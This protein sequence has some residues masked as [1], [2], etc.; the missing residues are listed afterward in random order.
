MMKK[1]F[2]FLA[3]LLAAQLIWAVDQSYY[4]S[5]EGKQGSDLRA[6]L[7]LLLY[8]RHTTF[9]SYNWDFPY[10]YDSEGNMLDIYSSCGFN[11][12]NK[13]ESS[14]KCCCDA[15]NREHV[16]C[17]SN[18][19]GSDNNGKIPQYSDRHHL[20]P[21][22]GRA[23]G[24]RSDLPFG[25]CSKG[26]HG[27]CNSSSTVYPGEGT[28]T[29]EN[30]EYGR[31][32]ASTFSVALPSGGGN[33]YEVGDEYKGDIAR[34]ILYMVVRYAEKTYCRLPDGAKNA[35][36]YLKTANEYPVTAWANTTQNKVGQMFSPSLSTN[37]GLS[38]YGK[39]LLLKWHR[40]DPVSQKEIDRNAGVE[41]A[42]GNR[43]PFVDYPY[44]VEYLWGEQSTKTFSRN[45]VVGSFESGFVPGESNGS[46]ESG[47]ATTYFSVTL[48]RND[49]ATVLSGLTGT[50]NL[51]TDED[52]ACENWTFAGWSTTDVSATTTQPA[53]ITSVNSEQQVY[54]VY[55]NAS[56]ESTSTNLT[57]V[58]I[59]DVNTTVGN[60]TFSADKNDGG[61]NPTY[62]ENNK[63]LRYY[64]KNSLTISS[65]SI[66]TQI[67]FT[68]S[69]QGLKRLAPITANV[70]SIAT[71]KAGDKTVTWTG[72]AT[73]VTFTVGEKADYGSD[74][75]GKA[76]QLCVSSLAI[77]SGA[78]YT[79]NSTP[80][81]PKK[82]I[83]VTFMNNGKEFATSKGEEGND[84]E[85]SEPVPCSGYEFEG[86]SSTECATE[87]DEMPSLDFNGHIP[88]EDVTYYAVYSRTQEEEEKL[89]T[90]EYKKITT[91]AELT[92]ANYLVVA[93][94][95]K[96]LAMST[97]WKKTYYLAPVEIAA[98]DNII[99]TEGDT[100]IWKITVNGN[101]LTFFNTEKK[102]LY[103]EQSGKHYNIKLG[104]N[105]ENNKFTYSVTDGKWI[106]TSSTYTDRQIEFYKKNAYWA[107]YTSQDA[108][109]Y[110]YKQ[111]Q[112]TV[113]TTYYT[114][115]PDCPDTPTDIDY[116]G[117]P[118]SEWRK[119]LRN[120]QLYIIHGEHMYT[121]QGL[122]IQ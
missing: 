21:V 111:I 83:T 26:S 32:G 68:L 81:C 116:T 84:I 51:P 82:L 28:S 30:H 122:Q 95:S 34:A 12:N 52:A 25:E 48:H 43:N 100:I 40:Q 114:T 7:T 67:V 105:T 27:S 79:Y 90:N 18:F 8:E 17:Q 33:V 56:G 62:N 117:Q 39:A 63:D 88:A 101:Q 80:E 60:F 6:A 3:L 31:A 24:H 47:G 54:A 2:S 11:S 109:I 69:E 119:V 36:T 53:F 45:D 5:L 71:Q 35:T 112:Q 96:L 77:N 121:V 9:V 74:G 108:P 65:T 102:Y 22:D 110:L 93:D 64:A 38:D 4:S 91:T 55:K 13:Y 61:T 57:A 89:L 94:T 76:G 29:C 19:G 97:N 72:N 50:Y 104:D 58:Q 85:L 120:G 70:G 87:T 14:Y 44:L 118:K 37:F 42:Q 73:S 59:G 113:Y 15:I 99:T 1:T 107:F 92:N 103:I 98:S 16:V 20:Y 46:K 75:S 115:A 106:F 66:I 78:S 49:K 23:N 86:W 10:D 41:A